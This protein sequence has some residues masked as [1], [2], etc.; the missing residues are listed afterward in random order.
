MFTTN[1]P[2]PCLGD[3]SPAELQIAMNSLGLKPT[4]AEVKEMIQEID[5]DGDG[6]IDFNGTSPH[7]PVPSTMVPSDADG[8]QTQSS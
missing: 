3:I 6:Q 4:L 2:P 1:P 8:T 5:A 7:C